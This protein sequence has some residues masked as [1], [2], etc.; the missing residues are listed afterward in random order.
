MLSI[1]IVLVIDWIFSCKISKLVTKCRNGSWI[2]YNIPIYSTCWT[3][4]W[5]TSNISSVSSNIYL[6]FFYCLAICFQ[7]WWQT[8]RYLLSILWRNRIEKVYKNGIDFC[9]VAPWCLAT[10]AKILP[11]S[12]ILLRKIIQIFRWKIFIPM[13]EVDKS[14]DL[15]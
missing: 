13:S 3:Y 14:V 8:P 2:F 11:Y 9:F 7:F 10:L 4:R 12:F 5:M 1:T 15:I 6:F